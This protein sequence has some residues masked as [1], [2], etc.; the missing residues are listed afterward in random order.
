MYGLDSLVAQRIFEQFNIQTPINRVKKKIN[1]TTLEEL[2]AIPYLS[3]E[4]AKKIIGIRTK[5]PNLNLKEF[6][7]EMDFDSLKIKRLTLYLY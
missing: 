7:F 6:F 5:K 4:E 3:Y 2:Q 1:K